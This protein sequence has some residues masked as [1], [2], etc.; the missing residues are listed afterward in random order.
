MG[1][2]VEAF[3]TGGIWMYLVL[4][5]WMLGGIV[6]FV[7]TILAALGK[8]VP[9][10]V[11]ALCP[12]GVL[13]LAAL[14]AWFGVA[15]AFEALRLATPETRQV[16]LARGHALELNVTAFGA[17]CAMSLSM[18]GAMGWALGSAIGVGKPREWTPLPAIL[19]LILGLLVSA[20]LLGM[21]VMERYMGLW[22]F[23][24][25]VLAFFGTLSC[26]LVNLSMSTEG[27]A[28]AARTASARLGVASLVFLALVSMGWMGKAMGLIEVF[29]ALAVATPANRV[30][31]VARGTAMALDTFYLGLA[32]AMGAALFGLLPSLFSIKHALD[33]RGLIGGALGVGF[34]VV[35]LG[36]IFGA[37]AARDALPESHLPRQ[38]VERSSDLRAPTAQELL[39]EQLERQQWNMRWRRASRDCA[40]MHQADGWALVGAYVPDS[41]LSASA[42][43]ASA[44]EGE[45]GAGCPS[46]AGAL[47]G[48]LCA[49]LDPIGVWASAGLPA[50]TVTRHTWGPSLRRLVLALDV[51]LGLEFDYIDPLLGVMIWNGFRGVELHWMPEDT[52]AEQ[53]GTV[54]VTAAPRG[55]S[56]YLVT[57]AEKKQTASDPLV[58]LAVL[59]SIRGSED[60]QVPPVIVSPDQGWSLEELARVCL[61]THM[62]IPAPGQESRERGLRVGREDSPVGCRVWQASPPKIPAP[63]PAAKKQ[64]ESGEIEPAPDEPPEDFAGSVSWSLRRKSAKFQYCYEREL[65][66]NPKASGKVTVSFVIGQVGRVTSSEVVEDTVGGGM[67]DCVA[68]VVRRMRFRKPENGSAAV[69]KS[70]VFSSGG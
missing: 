67:G 33:R 43:V 61:I 13:A 8:R 12:L 28:D 69:Q 55:R 70:L 50:S 59:K 48:P 9:W 63:R 44:P 51:S 68:N 3:R 41:P 19:A 40:I 36:T 54:F 27:E 21:A 57:S 23:S 2:I 11:W 37:Q 16:L 5:V 15:D 4:L 14:G 58:L 38:F 60:V 20:G 56:G 66:A 62:A 42:C 26:A 7:A 34:A 32:G 47:E 52:P 30:S 10:L 45:E 65:Q 46:Q 1:A 22:G 53:L 25:G 31:L 17:F 35:C 64:P 18:L 49:G 6:A 39:P 29:E 24:I